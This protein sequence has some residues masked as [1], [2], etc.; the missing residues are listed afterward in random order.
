MAVISTTTAA[1]EVAV[2]GATLT[3][4]RPTVVKILL[5]VIDFL[6]DPTLVNPEKGYYIY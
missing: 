4:L 3:F 6:V 2:F 1:N 5:S